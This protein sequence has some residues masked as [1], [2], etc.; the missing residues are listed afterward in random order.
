MR[1]KAWALVVCAV[2]AFTPGWG[3]VACARER[4]DDS[5][6]DVPS[7]AVPPLPPPLESASAAPDPRAWHLELPRAVPAANIRDRVWAAPPRYGSELTSAALYTV[8]GI[9]PAGL[10]LVDRLGQRVDNVPAAVVHRVKPPVKLR[11]G[12]VVLCYGPTL[13]AV[14]ARVA[15]IKPGQEIRVR[16]D[17]AGSTRETNIL[18]AEPPEIDIKPMAY[19]G[20]PKAGGVSRGLLIALSEQRGWVL[21]G[22]GHVEV[23]RRADLSQLPLLP[24]D[25]AVGAKVQA[26]AWATGYLEGTVSEILEPRLRY[27]VTHPGNKPP[28]DYFFSALIRA[29]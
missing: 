27:R 20:F 17:W 9:T 3:L 15:E 10:S 4:A 1:A 14:L 5:K 21:T 16:Y 22:S 7:G 25:L 12:D 29:P 11:E 19:V 28:R 23:H 6:L 8:D 24:A 26:Y 13:P 18:H 2:A